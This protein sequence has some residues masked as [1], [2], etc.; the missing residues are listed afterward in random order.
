MWLY[1]FIS[2]KNTDI[3]VNRMDLSWDFTTTNGAKLDGSRLSTMA[4]CQM[5]MPQRHFLQQPMTSPTMIHQHSGRLMIYILSHFYICCLF[6]WVAAITANKYYFSIHPRDK[7][8]TADRLA[9]S[10]K[11][12]M[13]NVDFHTCGPVVS[14]KYYITF[15]M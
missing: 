14:I 12:L 8:T 4:V 15:L 7:Q 9:N 10:A 1:N 13:Y 11:S 2:H 6:L 3:Y 5:Q